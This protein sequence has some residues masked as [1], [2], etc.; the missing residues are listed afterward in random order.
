MKESEG[1][2][3]KSGEA[4]AG[5]TTRTY[6]VIWACL[7]VLTAITVT[8][9]SL[10]FGRVAVLVAL[11]VASV[12]SVLVLLYFMHLRYER[13]RLIRLIVPIALVVLAIFIGLTYS[14]VLTRG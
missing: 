1:V 2:P 5:A 10:D 4:H 9:A 8:T 13:R 6:L 14:D 12:K 11:A 3:M 7:L